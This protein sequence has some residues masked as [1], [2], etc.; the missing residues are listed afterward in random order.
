MSAALNTLPGSLRTIAPDPVMEEFA[1][2]RTLVV[3]LAA[4]VST[5][6]VPLLARLLVKAMIDPGTRLR[7]AV[8]TESVR[9][10]IWNPL[11][12]LQGAAIPIATSKAALFG[13]SG[14]VSQ[15]P[16]FSQALVPAPFVHVA[17][18]PIARADDAAS[19]RQ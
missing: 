10:L 16:A 3:T 8:L 12:R 9:E 6:I 1:S 7:F 5:R 14:L 19:T 17:V 15:L 11:E 18:T 4:V 2:K 13:N